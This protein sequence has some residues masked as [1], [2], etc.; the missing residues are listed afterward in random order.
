MKTGSKNIIL[1]TLLQVYSASSW[2]IDIN[3]QRHRKQQSNIG[4]EC[5]RCP[6]SSSPSNKLIT[7]REARILNPLKGLCLAE[8]FFNTVQP[9]H[10]DTLDK[11]AQNPLQKYFQSAVGINDIPAALTKVL[12]GF[13]K[14]NTLLCTSVC[15]DEVNAGFINVLGGTY[16]KAFNLAGLGGVP[17]VGISGMGAAVSH[18]P[19]QGNI[20]IV[21]GSHVGYSPSKE[22]LGKVRRSGKDK[23]SGACGAAIG[24]LAKVKE[25][26][27]VK[28]LK[29]SETNNNKPP[30]DFMDQIQ[31][32]Q[33]DYIIEQ[34]LAS[35]NKPK[36]FS[37][38]TDATAWVTY[39]VLDIAQQRLKSIIDPITRS[40]SFSTANLVVLGGVLINTGSEGEDLFQ[41][42]T[43]EVAGQD[44][45]QDFEKALRQVKVDAVRV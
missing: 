12:P 22:L 24:A 40:P 8:L 30:K 18:I 14:S 32:I 9:A 11:T 1:G 44:L 3:L 2:N 21:V 29:E 16:G 25:G 35:T 42:V 26:V 33:E 38:D 20:I 23:L 27:T 17:Y 7:A 15:S 4:L 45:F 41:P 6:S 37:D 5:N 31:D 10:A 19:D 28:D 43:F 13:T 36:D 39:E 34:L